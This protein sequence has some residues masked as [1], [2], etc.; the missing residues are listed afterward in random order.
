MSYLDPLKPLKKSVGRF[1]RLYRQTDLC[2][3]DVL[4]IKINADVLKA[5]LET[6]REIKNEIKCIEMGVNIGADGISDYFAAEYE[7]FQKEK[8]CDNEIVEFSKRVIA[9]NDIMIATLALYSIKFLKVIGRNFCSMMQQLIKY[10]KHKRRNGDL[11]ICKKIMDER[12]N[13]RKSV[14]KFIRSNAKIVRP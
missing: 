13:Y 3:D 5:L 11:K 12:K 14:N 9:D 4:N 6:C 2:N 1:K 8:R 7:I 10:L